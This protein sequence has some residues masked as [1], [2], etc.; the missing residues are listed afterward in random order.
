[1]TGAFQFLYNQAGKAAQKRP[2]YSEME[3]KFSAES[4]RCKNLEE[5]SQAKI[6]TIQE[7]YRILREEKVLIFQKIQ[8]LFLHYVIFRYKDI[9]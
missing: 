6:Q 5:T 1:M 7:E 3:K 2:S 4:Q 8:L 9:I